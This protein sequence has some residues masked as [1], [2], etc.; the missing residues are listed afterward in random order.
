LGLLYVLRPGLVHCFTL[1][2]WGIVTR[3]GVFE[4]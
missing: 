3:V 4:G 2:K 1:G